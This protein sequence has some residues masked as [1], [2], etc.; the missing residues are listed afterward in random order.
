MARLSR[1]RLIIPAIKLIGP[2]GRRCTAQDARRSGDR[3]FQGGQGGEAVVLD[4]TSEGLTDFSWLCHIVT[5]A[6]AI[7]WVKIKCTMS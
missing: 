1:R 6:M 4:Y 7:R 2:P 5:A 3:D